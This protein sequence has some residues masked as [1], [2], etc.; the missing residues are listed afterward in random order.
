M[1]LMA[2]KSVQASIYTQDQKEKIYIYYVLIFSVIFHSIKYDLS[3]ADCFLNFHKTY[4][5]LFI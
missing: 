5:Y 1:Y 2:T 4:Y 3:R